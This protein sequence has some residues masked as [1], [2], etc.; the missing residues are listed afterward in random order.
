MNRPEQK[1]RSREQLKLVTNAILK[2]IRQID[3]VTQ[4][5]VA[6]FLSVKEAKLK[7]GVWNISACARGERTQAGG[8]IWEWDV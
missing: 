4:H 2:S 8:Y 3:P 5:V 7:T 6:R 1:E